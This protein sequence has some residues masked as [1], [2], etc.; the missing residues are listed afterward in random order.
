MKIKKF[1]I[2]LICGLIPFSTARKKLR[3]KLMDEKNLVSNIFDRLDG[4]KIILVRKDGT[5]VEVTEISGLKVEFNGKNSQITIY[6]PFCFENSYCKL[7]N[8]CEISVAQ[9]NSV[10][11]NLSISTRQNNKIVIGKNFSCNGCTME[12]HDE[13][14]T[15]IKIGDDCLFSYGIILRPSDGHTIYDIGSG[16]ILNQPCDGITIGNHVWV[17]MSAK[18]LKDSGVGNNTVVG[19]DSL[20]TRKFDEENVVVGG[21][22]AKV[23]KR[24][25]NWDIN[26]TDNFKDGYYRP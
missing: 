16:K 14:N 1:I 6:E 19:A 17:G 23:L 24:G 3:S 8:N 22:P 4:N 5:S 18:F 9:N 11:R 13:A 2:N 26:N 12:V 20:V 7:G 15:T 21:V 10:T 25:I